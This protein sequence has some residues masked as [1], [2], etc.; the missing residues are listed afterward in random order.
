MQADITSRQGHCQV[1]F[2]FR[3]ISSLMTRLRRNPNLHDTHKQ[4]QTALQQHQQSVVNMSSM[5]QS[6]FGNEVAVMEE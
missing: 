1:W 4:L 2:P 3:I 6:K 5:F